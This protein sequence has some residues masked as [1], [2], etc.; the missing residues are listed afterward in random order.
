MFKFNHVKHRIDESLFSKDTNES[1]NPFASDQF[2]TI[3]ET[4][5]YE[6]R[7]QNI[8]FPISSALIKN[9]FCSNYKIRTINN[10]SLDFEVIKI[11][12]S[13]SI[14]YNQFYKMPSP[15]NLIIGLHYF[16]YST[17][18]IEN[19]YSKILSLRALEVSDLLNQELK[20]SERLKSKEAT[21]QFNSTTKSNVSHIIINKNIVSNYEAADKIENY[22]DKK[23]TIDKKNFT[24][25][26]FLEY[27]SEQI[28]LLQKNNRLV[29]A[30]FSLEF[31][32]TSKL[33][34]E[35]QKDIEDFEIFH[36]R[37]EFGEYYDGIHCIDWVC[38]ENSQRISCRDS[39]NY[40]VRAEY[41]N[42]K[43]QRKLYDSLNY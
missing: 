27:L 17:L 23:Y 35:L 8:H 36:L 5:S 7:N 9:S 30:S 6:R 15:E 28:E 16:G 2:N 10:L 21:D 42:L 25:D 12:E 39:F 4:S 29:N 33:I 3:I 43:T 41:N 19:E 20:S 11:I 22:E 26:E 32:K 37:K 1:L 18:D 13:L 34:L 24:I 38:T 14:H 31:E 40:Q